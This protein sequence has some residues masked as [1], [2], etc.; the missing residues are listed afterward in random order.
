MKYTS[1][2]AAKLLRSLNEEQSALKQKERNSCSFIAAIGEDIESVRPAYDY[3][4]VQKQL[5]ELEK[6]IRMVK[7]SINK[8]NLEHVVPGFEMTIDQILV[9][10]PQ[11]SEKKQ[12]LSMMSSR[13]PKQRENTCG[14]TIIEYDY[15]NYDVEQAEMDYKEVSDELARAQIALDVINNS[16]TMEIEI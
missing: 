6:K 13:L 1:A 5:S 12:K 14:S 15:A 4:E 3:K 16:E 11:L 9:Y 10:I 7:H 8:F 2:E